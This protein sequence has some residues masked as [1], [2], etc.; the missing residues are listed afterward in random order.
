MLQFRRSSCQAPIHDRLSPQPKSESYVTHQA[1]FP[2]LGFVRSF[3]GLFVALL[4]PVLPS[5]TSFFR[6]ASRR[7]NSQPRTPRAARTEALYQY[8][9]QKPQTSCINL[10]RSNRY[11]HVTKVPN[12]KLRK[13]ESKTLQ[14]FSVVAPLPRPASRSRNDPDSPRPDPPPPWTQ[15]SPFPSAPFHPVTSLLEPH[16]TNSTVS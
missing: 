13:P 2:P 5:P 4:H 11:R 6:P 1:Q 14:P 9:L 7:Q 10:L 8:D 12:P 3:S 16:T 15:L